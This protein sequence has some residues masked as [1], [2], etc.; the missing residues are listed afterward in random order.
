MKNYLIIIATLFS[1]ISCQADNNN[2]EENQQSNMN[3]VKAVENND[4]EKVKS[5]LAEGINVETKGD[6]QRSLLLIATYNNNIEIAKVLLEAGANVN[7]QDA[8]KDSPFLYAG[9]QGKLELVELFLKYRPD[10]NIYNRYGGTA[11]IPAAE[12]GHPDVVKL[13][14]NTSGYPINHVNNLG[15]TALMEAIVLGTGGAIHTL[16]VKELVDAGA[17]INIPDS[18]GVSALNHA[19]DR[20]FTE[21]VKILENSTQ[22]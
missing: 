13:L 2:N 21:I 16:I 14:A 9:A 10:F 11:L 1:F 8:I 18:K 15:W 6:Q 7:T 4:I 3:I 19:K 20:G 22:K 5:L 17:D 12:K